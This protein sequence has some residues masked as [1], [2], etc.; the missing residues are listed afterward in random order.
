MS[1]YKT[2]PEFI[3]EQSEKMHL[4]QGQRSSSPRDISQVVV[5]LV[6]LSKAASLLED[7]AIS[8][9]NRLQEL[10]QSLPVQE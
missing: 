7:L 3:L 6:E 4:M 5:D 1:Q 2:E 10:A 8:I 9:G